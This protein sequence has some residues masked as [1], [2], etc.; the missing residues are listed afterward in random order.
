MRSDSN[1]FVDV[2]LFFETDFVEDKDKIKI[3]EVSSST[4]IV[5]INWKE[6]DRLYNTD[7]EKKSNDDELE[8]ES[9]MSLVKNGK[10][11]R[12][13]S[14]NFELYIELKVKFLLYG[15]IKIQ[16]DML[17]FV[18][19]IYI[20]LSM[21]IIIFFLFFFQGFNE[22][23]PS[24]MLIP[25]NSEELEF[26]LSGSQELNLEDWENNTKKINKY[27]KTSKDYLVGEN[28]FIWFF[29]MLKENNE[30][31]RKKVLRYVTGQECVPIGF[32]Y[33]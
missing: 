20:H 4:S 11:I 9:G 19:F 25:F 22:L 3:Y 31:F 26:V 5:N 1:Y 2:E 27:P 18:Y 15:Q 29:K 16:L 6:L 30:E 12:V 24:Y 14:E 23:I 32:F 13:T 33:F 21:F 17:K 10:N 8:C 28:N 7:N